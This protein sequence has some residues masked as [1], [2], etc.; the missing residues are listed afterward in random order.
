MVTTEILY[1]ANSVKTGT[2]CQPI[3]RTGEMVTTFFTPPLLDT[4]V[5]RVVLF[6]VCKVLCLSLLHTPR[7]QREDRTS[8]PPSPLTSNH[9]VP[10][11]LICTPLLSTNGAQKSADIYFSHRFKTA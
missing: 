7:Q 4:R 2:T 11:Q 6:R 5:N 10:G 9:R 8:P 3:T 1:L